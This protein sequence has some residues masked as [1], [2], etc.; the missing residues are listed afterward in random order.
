MGIFGYTNRTGFK[1]GLT[2]AQISEFSLVLIMLGVKMGHLTQEVLSFVTFIGLVTIAGSTYMIMYSEKIYPHLS[3]Y[4]KIFEK[5]KVK[6][7]KTK[8][9]KCSAVLFGYNRIGFDILKSLKKIKKE[10]LVVDYNPDTVSTLEKFDIPVVYGDA[11]DQDLI[12]ELPVDKLKL[13]VSTI[14]ELDVNRLLIE[15]FKAKNK[16]TIIIV[17]AH[18]INEAMELY[19]Y[20]ADY[21]L[22]PHFLGGEYL[23]KMISN[24]KTNRR[25][26]SKEKKKHIKILKERQK[27]NHKHPDIDKN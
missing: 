7:K 18:S 27:I 24:I 8:I 22:T 10:Y 26:Y 1:A 23:A 11:Y 4:L 5:R 21:V 15:S 17:R 9:K 2:V 14:P 20:G 12:E 13:V 25:E 3:K 6:E 19:D 16:N